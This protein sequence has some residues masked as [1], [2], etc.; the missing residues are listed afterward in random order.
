MT[1]Y[2]SFLILFLLLS[3]CS[4]D[5]VLSKE[6]ILR[7]SI[8]EIETRFEAR[9]LGDI[10]E[11]V[12]EDY[13][14]ENGRK[15]ADVKRVIQL[16]L[17]RHKKLFIISKIGDIQWQGDEKAI[18]QITAAMTGQEV[19]DIGI[20]PSIR[21]DIV[22]FTVEFV[23]QEEVFKIKAATWTWAQPSDFL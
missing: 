22:N 6:Q 15:L 2:L 23:K 1:K 14:D 18:V 10:V 13:K 11:Y 17:M 19:E 8:N 5:P 12:S 7:N 3:S 16:Q 4:S 20:L 9:R 21:A